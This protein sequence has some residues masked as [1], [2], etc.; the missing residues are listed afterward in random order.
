MKKIIIILIIGILITGCSTIRIKERKDN[1]YKCSLISTNEGI[2]K[3][4]EFSIILNKRKEPITYIIKGG[5][6]NYKEKQKEYNNMCDT[7][8]SDIKKESLEKYK[9]K[10][11]IKVICNSNNN[12]QVY[13]KK[14]YQIKEI[15]DIKDLNNINNYIKNYTNEDK[16]F[17]LKKWKESFYINTNN[18]Y[19][20][21]F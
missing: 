14:A 20:C 6:K 10:L 18:N 3:I 2:K 9:N 21:N 7:L 5:Y 13:I 17:N 19:I 11:E 12:N 1:T 16:T 8:K 15:K 4:S